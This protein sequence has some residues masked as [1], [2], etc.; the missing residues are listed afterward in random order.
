MHTKP[1]LSTASSLAQPSLPLA[2]YQDTRSRYRLAIRSLV[3]QFKSKYPRRIYRFVPK[4]VPMKWTTIDSSSPDLVY[5]SMRDVVPF[6]SVVWELSGLK[7]TSAG[8][9]TQSKAIC[10]AR[11]STDRDPPWVCQIMQG[12]FSSEEAGQIRV[13]MAHI[14]AVVN[15]YRQLHESFLTL[16]DLAESFSCAEDLPLLGDGLPPNLYAGLPSRMQFRRRTRDV[17]AAI[18]EHG[19]QV[20]D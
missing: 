10:L 16:L 11:L 15:R 13:K 19:F 7:R 3:T 17:S 12:G 14:N 1:A 6:V 20:E 9:R 18:G 8:G 5:N 2:Q 4:L